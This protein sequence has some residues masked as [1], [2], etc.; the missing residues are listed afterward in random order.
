MQ[1]VV[2]DP[3]HPFIVFHHLLYHG[4][5]EHN[6]FGT[7]FNMTNDALAEDLIQFVT[8]DPNHPLIVFHQLLYH[9]NFE[10][11]TNALA[12]FFAFGFFDAKS[13][14]VFLLFLT[15]ALIQFVILD[16]NHPL[17]VLNHLLYHANFEHAPNTAAFFAF[18]SIIVFLTAALIQFVTLDP[19]H[20]LIVL[21]HLL[22]HGNFEH[23]SNTFNLGAFAFKS[24]IV[25]LLF[26]TAA[27]IQ[28]VILILLNHALIVLNHFLYHGNLA[29]E[30]RAAFL[31]AFLAF[32]AA[33][34]SFLASFGAAGLAT[35]LAAGLATGLAAGLAAG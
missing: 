32:L 15:A 3:N 6:N 5:F 29:H 25:F 22:Y 1:F 33:F 23:E 35:G 26:L 11:K 19:N 4:N 34:L 24:I 21:N 12:A 30:G 20:P 18:K 16:P 28:F 10:H 27:L 2:L 7:A 9:A 31:A 8:L 17:I 14:I 13:I